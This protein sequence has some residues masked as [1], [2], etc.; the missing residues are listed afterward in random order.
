MATETLT[1][2]IAAL[3]DIP[4]TKS[5]QK[6]EATE[7]SKGQR[8]NGREEPYRYAH[9]LPTFN[10]QR[11]PPLEPYEHVDPGHRALTHP[12]P[13]SFLH[14]ASSVTEVTPNLGTEVRGVNLA[15]LT[16]DERDQ[17]ALEVN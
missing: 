17:V 11:Y 3:S 6:P 5:E 15:A 2:T 4:S 1:Q 14:S 10:S 13:R 12:D 7:P 9:L 8:L 16:N